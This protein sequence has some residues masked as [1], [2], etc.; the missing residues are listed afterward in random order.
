MRARAAEALARLTTEPEASV[1]A[2]AA[3]LADKSDDVRNAA[4]HAL[5]EF[6]ASAASSVPALL[7]ALADG[8]VASSALH[9]LAQFGAGAAPNRCA[10]RAGHIALSA[11]GAAIVDAEDGG[12]G[13]IPGAAR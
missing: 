7:V 1:P 12:R 4:A 9:S 8:P 2:L 13:T 6:P 5:G 10:T 11:W 3:A